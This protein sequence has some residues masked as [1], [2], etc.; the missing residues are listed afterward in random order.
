MALH[1][2]LVRQGPVEGSQCI[3]AEC[4]HVCADIKVTVKDHGA[5]SYSKESDD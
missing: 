1:I 5:N 2:F 4:S 3:Y